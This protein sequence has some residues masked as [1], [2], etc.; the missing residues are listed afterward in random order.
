MILRL[1][2]RGSKVRDLQTL[3]KMHGKWTY[4][5][6]TDFFGKVTE[7][8]VKEFQRSVGLLDDGIVGNKTWTELLKTVDSNI[9][10]VCKECAIEDFS[11]PEEE[12]IIEDVDEVQPTC[13]NTYELIKL[14]KDSLI[15]RNVT[16][17]VFHCTAT[18]QNATVEGILRY[19]R[20]KLKWRNPGYHIIIK[21]DGSWTLLSDFNNITNGVQGINSTSLHVSYIG[22]IDK[23]GRPIDNRTDKQKEILEIIY[24]EFKEKM[25]NLTFHGH[26]EFSNKAC[27]SYNVKDFIELIED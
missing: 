15:T 13:P 20:N 5:T 19:W 21:P 1:N 22:G 2:S 12:M 9:K 18:S 3:L 16:R 4:H 27:P 14:I 8:A 25:K 17:L 24:N 11:D 26:Y 6:I 23:N 7:S 10:P